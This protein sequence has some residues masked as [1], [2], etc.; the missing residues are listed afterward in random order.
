MKVMVRAI[1]VEKGTVPAHENAGG[2][3]IRTHPPAP[4]YPPNPNA[5]GYAMCMP[6]AFSFETTQG[7][8]S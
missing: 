5:Q 2:I 6:E 1:P 8:E 3:F 7:Y 4:K